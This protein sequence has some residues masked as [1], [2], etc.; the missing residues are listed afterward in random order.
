MKKRVTRAIAWVGLLVLML[1]GQ[2]AWAQQPT[3][4]QLV[5]EHRPLDWEAVSLAL[6][7]QEVET[8]AA[9]E[10]LTDFSVEVVGNTISIIYRDLQF[11][12]DSPEITPETGEKI[13]SLSRVLQRFSDRNLRV[14][15]HTAQVPDDPDDGTVLSQQ[16]AQAV[17]DAMVA[18]GFFQRNLITAVGRGENEPIAD[19]D[20]PEGRALNRRV[21]I[22][23]FDQ[24][25]EGA[26]APQSVWWKQY[27]D[28]KAPGATVFVVDS[29]VTSVAAVR[30]ALREEQQRSGAPVGDLPV[31]LTSEGIAVVYDQAEFTDRDLPT[32]ATRREVIGLADALVELDPNAQVRV[33][34]FGAELPDERITERHYQLG[35]AIAAE[36]EV[37]PAST[38]VGDRPQSFRFDGDGFR[39]GSTGIIHSM[40]LSANA[41]LPIER[42]GEFS[43]L[44]IGVG[45]K[46]DVLVPGFQRN[47]ALAPI[48]FG[49]GVEGLYHIPNDTSSVETLW[50]FGWMLTAGYALPVSRTFIVTPQLGYGG[51]VHVLTFTQEEDPDTFTAVDGRSHYSQTLGVELDFAWKPETWIVGDRTMVGVFLRPGYRVFFDEDYLGHSITARLGARFYF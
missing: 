28:W 24:V 21:E 19:N 2:P 43:R 46:F 4:V 22:S 36:S 33:G 49:L 23:V 45:A 51:T 13:A 9:D 50:E 44:G 40:E 14:E 18:T 6:L 25:D 10:G 1:A 35:L 39:S 42:Y 20:T 12:P 48:R 11:P 17:A 5:D 38:L 41:S 16:R 3:R 31:V 27:T 47:R 26:T 7:V 8:A 15:G 37:Q 32:P 34:G 29:L 30:A